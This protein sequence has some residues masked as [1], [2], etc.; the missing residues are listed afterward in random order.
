MLKMNSFATFNAGA[1]RRLLH[2]LVK[3]LRDAKVVI[4]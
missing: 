1:M 3:K 2:K 4:A